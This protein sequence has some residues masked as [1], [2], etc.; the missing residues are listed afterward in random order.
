MQAIQEGVLIND[1]P[2]FYNLNCTGC[3]Y[4]MKQTIR[5]EKGR[6]IMLCGSSECD[7]FD[8]STPENIHY[9]YLAASAGIPQVT[10]DI[11]GGILETV[12]FFEEG[13]HSGSF[14]YWG[15]NAEDAIAVRLGY[16]LFDAFGD[17]LT[18]AEF[19]AGL[20]VFWDVLQRPHPDLIMPALIDPQE[21]AQAY[22][23]Y[24]GA[25]E[26]YGQ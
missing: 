19:Q 8:Y 24:P 25:L 6:M 26:Y 13:I 10:S 7:W 2:D 18:V 5:T 3:V 1:L 23:Y 12:T 9:G 11:A 14:R 20:D 17:D 22:V 15:E 21:E 16:A 4:D